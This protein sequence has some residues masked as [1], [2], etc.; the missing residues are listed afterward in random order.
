[1]FCG[2]A[3]DLLASRLGRVIL[4][5]HDFHPAANVEKLKRGVASSDLDRE[6][7][8]G[9]IHAELLSLAR[10]NRD[11]VLACSA[12]KQIYRQRLWAGAEMRVCYLAGSFREMAERL[13][14]RVG[15]L[16][17][18]GILGEQFADME[19]PGDAL[20]LRVG[21][22]AEEIVGIV[23]RGLRSV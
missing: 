14:R 6:P 10:E 19:E 16:A 5:A 7:W 23:L 8:L 12:L 15:H 22:R 21:H 18:E 20:V 17:A 9:T 11:A 3:A 2:Q 13:K 4:D 1:M